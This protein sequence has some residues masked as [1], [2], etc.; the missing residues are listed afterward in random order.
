MKKFKGA[1]EKENNINEEIKA[2][3]IR[4]VDIAKYG[5]T[6]GIYKR[7]EALRIAEEL[8]LDLIEISS[9]SEPVIC[10]IEDY[11][12]FLYDKKKKNK[13]KVSVQFKG[14]E[15]VFKEKGEILLLKLLQ[16]VKDLGN[17]ENL[18]KL[19]GRKMITIIN[20]K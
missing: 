3:N 17:P 4:V 15:I 13:V 10:K 12:K 1:K 2:V 9:N 8:E 6:D 16:E 7:I 19:E 11:S 18:P 5:K 20:P 14:R